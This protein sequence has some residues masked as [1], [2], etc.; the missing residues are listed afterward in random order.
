MIVV[1][2]IGSSE[3]ELQEVCQKAEALGFSPHVIYG[4][5]RNV[6]GLVGLGDRD[7]VCVIEDMPG[8]DRVVPISKPYKLASKEV[9]KESSIVDV[10]G[11]K[12]GGKRLR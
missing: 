8:V 12:F 7:N 5:E 1:M 4:K 9:K 10:C 6:V 3:N 11:V 2:Q